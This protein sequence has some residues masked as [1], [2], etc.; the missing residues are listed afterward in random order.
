MNRSCSLPCAVLLA[1]ALGLITTPHVS[2]ANSPPVVSNVVA[3]QVAGTGNVQ[4]SFDVSDADGDQVTARVICSSDNG[5]TFDLLPVTLSGE[6]NHPM[7]PG[8][9]KQVTWDAAKDYPG[10]YWTQVVAKVYASDG[11][12]ASGEMVPV[13]AG[14]FLMGSTASYT[15]EQPQHSVNLDA[16]SID[17][18]EVTNAQFK[19]FIDAGGYATQ[20]FWSAAGWNWKNGNN[21]I[22]PQ[23]WTNGGAHGGPGWPD[24]PVM[25]V[26]WYEAEAYANF[27]GKQLPTEAQWEKAAK[28]PDLWTYPFGNALGPDRANYY[29][30][31]DPWDCCNTSPVGFFDGRLHPNPPFQTTNSPSPYGAYDMSGNVAEWTRD[32]YQSDYY[33]SSPASNP[34][35]PVAGNFKV[36]RGGSSNNQYCPACLTSTKRSNA[37]DG[38]YGTSTV[39]SARSEVLGFRCVRAGQ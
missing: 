32:W 3:H 2:A 19:Q 1:G 26:S 38:Q 23:Y 37:T 11:F 36:N 28:G 14:A 24:F 17:K 5:T 33:A 16:F 9:G 4:I 10:R 20:A 30:S 7:A 6:V 31:G 25:G 13:A 34:I 39:P 22:Q 21:I 18:Y 29:L 8:S 27:V 12:A 35:G 15:D